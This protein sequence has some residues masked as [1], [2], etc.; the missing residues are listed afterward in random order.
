M[1]GQTHPQVATDTVLCSSCKRN[2]QAGRYAPHLEKCLGKVRCQPRRVCWCCVLERSAAPVEQEKD[3]RMR[4]EAR[5]L[6]ASPSKVHGDLLLDG[7]SRLYQAPLV[8]RSQEP[9]VS[10]DGF[11][12]P[13]APSVFA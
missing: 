5:L 3:V 11:P 2:V 12:A 6:A 13:R 4:L 9:S 10:S 1:F 8:A 7:Y